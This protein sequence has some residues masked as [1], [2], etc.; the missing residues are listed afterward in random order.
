ME[1]STGNPSLK[2]LMRISLNLKSHN[3]LK[4]ELLTKVNGTQTGKNVGEEYRSGKMDPFM[5]A[6]GLTIRPMAVVA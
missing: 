2:A 4:M 6:F 5:K 1:N 3:S